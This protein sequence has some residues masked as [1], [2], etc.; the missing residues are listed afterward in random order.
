MS[1][2]FTD[3]LYISPGYKSELELNYVVTS[4]GTV[5]VSKLILS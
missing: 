4:Q 3:T 2:D 5:I 1:R